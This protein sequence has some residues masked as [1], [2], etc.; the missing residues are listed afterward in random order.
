MTTPHASAPVQAT[1][2]KFA[3]SNKW[4]DCKRIHR[5]CDV[6]L[7]CGA[8]VGQTAR[9]LRQ[10][11][12]D[13]TIYCFEPV[14]AVFEQL[15]TQADALRICPVQAAVSNENGLANIHLTASPESNSLLDFLEHDNPLAGPHRVVGRELARICRLDDWCD[16]N[17]VATDR[18]DLLKMDVQGNELEALRGAT[19]ILQTVRIVLLEVAFVPFY[20]DCPLHD[21]I[22]SF[23]CACGFRRKAL[24]PSAHSDIWADAIYVPDRCPKLSANA[25]NSTFRSSK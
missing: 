18:V 11:Y 9:N 17:H 25:N 3:T 8:N 21:D 10:A 23:M 12:P 4:E 16:E 6:V 2:H 7:D 14:R 1:T 19:R 13:A 22:A 5:H 24:Y 20:R 15:Q